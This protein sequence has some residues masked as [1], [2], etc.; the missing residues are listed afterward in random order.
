MLKHLLQ[1]NSWGDGIGHIVLH[2]V[3]QQVLS[4]LSSGSRDRKAENQLCYMMT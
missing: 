1:Y 4:P 2:E 3:S